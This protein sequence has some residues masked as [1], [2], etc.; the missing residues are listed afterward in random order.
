MNKII[1]LFALLLVSLGI[2]FS[3]GALSNPVHADITIGET[4]SNNLNIGNYA[5]EGQHVKNNEK[6]RIF[7]N[8]PE[9]VKVSRGG[10]KSLY[11]TLVRF[12]RDLKNFFFAIATIFYLIIVLRLI[13]S[14]NTDEELG[15][16]KK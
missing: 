10:E 11:Y 2:L 8:D 14:S 9:F 7:G 15:N 13:L 3:A 16:F 4:N 1:R 5:G 12:A 6:L